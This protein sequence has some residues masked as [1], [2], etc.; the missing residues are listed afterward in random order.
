MKA[1]GGVE[2]QFHTVL[3]VALDGGEWSAS[4]SG[5]LTP[6]NV[7]TFP[8]NVRYASDIPGLKRHGYEG[9]GLK[10]YTFRTASVNIIQRPD[11]RTS[12]LYLRYIEIVSINF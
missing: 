1:Y 6:G 9:R 8:Y 12:R 5:H 10:H 3:T 7:T 2:V 11:S 4:R